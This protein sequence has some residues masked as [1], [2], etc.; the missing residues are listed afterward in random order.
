MREHPVDQLVVAPS[1]I[2]ETEL[3]IRRPLL[4][5]Q[6][7][8]RNAHRPDQLDQP[9][10]RGRRLQIFDDD[11]LDAALADHR[12]GVARGAAVRIVVDRDD[13]HAVSATS[14]GPRT[15]GRPSNQRIS[16][17][18]KMAPASSATMKPGRS[19]GRMP[20][21]VL[22]SERAMATAGLAN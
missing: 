7:A 22:V 20:E 15:S 1:G 21:N 2:V 8:D 4:P 14:T 9:L 12:Q 19:S 6:R 17:A 16:S 3:A 5:Q 13:H 11:R 18:P 10:A